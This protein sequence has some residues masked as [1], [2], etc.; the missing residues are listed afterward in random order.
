M[1]KE[2]EQ[3]LKSFSTGTT[4]LS[5]RQYYAM[6]LSAEDTL[7]L[8]GATGGTTARVIGILQNDPLAGE[9]G[10]VCMLGFTKAVVNAGT[11]IAAMNF[12]TCG[13]AGRL[14]K[15]TTAGS[16]F[17]GRALEAATN[18]HEIIDIFVCPGFLR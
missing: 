17:I 8:G 13:S 7:A 10:Q 2:K 4:D 5:T 3:V 12:L 6:R 18:T 15:L 16:F 11:D 1:A 14:V 9:N